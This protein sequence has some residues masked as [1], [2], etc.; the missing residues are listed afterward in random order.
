MLLLLL[1]RKY[2][3]SSTHTRTHT[4]CRC[5]ALSLARRCIALSTDNIRSLP[6]DALIGFCRS[7]KSN[8]CWSSACATFAFIVVVFF[9]CDE[10]IYCH[11]LIGIQLNGNDCKRAYSAVCARAERLRR[12]ERKKNEKQMTKEP[13]TK[14]R[15]SI[16]TQ[17]THMY[18]CGTDCVRA[19]SANNQ[20]RI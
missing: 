14:Q 2:A 15:I 20:M 6:I 8:W 11:T 10:Y 4:P 16:H 5:L 9:L 18:L 12:E 7:C 19:I 3:L 13:A 17:H 1:S